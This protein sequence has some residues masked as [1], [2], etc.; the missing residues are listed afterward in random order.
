[1]DSICVLKECFNPFTVSLS[2]FNKNMN[3][4]QQQ[5]WI[6]PLESTYTVERFHLSGDTFRFHWTVQDLNIASVKFSLGIEKVNWHVIEI[7]YNFV[8]SLY[9]ELFV[10]F[11]MLCIFINKWVSKGFLWYFTT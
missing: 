11:H 4:V 9:I 8:E 6:I 5:L 1:M 10:I 2:K 3:S 7:H